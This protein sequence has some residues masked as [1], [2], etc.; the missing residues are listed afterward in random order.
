MTQ[1][2]SEVTNEGYSSE[3]LTG[4]RQTLDSYEESHDSAV[5]DSLPDDIIEQVASGQGQIFEALDGLPQGNNQQSSVESQPSPEPEDLNL[6]YKRKADEANTWKQKFDTLNRKAEETLDFELK[7]QDPEFRSKYFEGKGYT[8]QKEIEEI[9]LTVPLDEDGEP[10]YFDEDYQKRLNQSLSTYSKDKKAQAELERQ[11]E[12]ASLSQKSVERTFQ[13]FDELQGKYPSLKTEKSFK[14]L[15]TEFIDFKKSLG[16]DL[17]RYMEDESFRTQKENDG[18]VAPR[19]LDKYLTLLDLNSRKSK[20]PSLEA[21]YRDSSMY[22]EHILSQAQNKDTHTQDTNKFDMLG[23]VDKLKDEINQPMGQGQGGGNVGGSEDDDISF[24][25]RWAGR[26]HEM[27][28]SD[29]KQYN[30]I[31]ARL[32]AKHGGGI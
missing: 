5:L 28:D 3:Q 19:E 8:T 24:M 17:K 2:N 26:E 14:E 16:T 23:K 12:R 21:A 4:F 6:K 1:E 29:E 11:A 22:D 20:Y 32:D 10:D 30:T 18:I 31:I 9:D 13:E 27:S 25:Q 15:D 7:L